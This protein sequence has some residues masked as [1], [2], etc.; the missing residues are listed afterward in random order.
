METTTQVSLG[1][2]A[3]QRVAVARALLRAYDPWDASEVEW[4]AIHPDQAGGVEAVVRRLTEERSREPV[5]FPGGE[6]GEHAAIIVIPA[7][8]RDTMTGDVQLAGG[9]VV[10]SSLKAGEAQP[11][12]DEDFPRSTTDAL[13]A[14]ALY[15]CGDALCAL[16]GT[17]VHDLPPVFVAGCSWPG[18]PDLEA[19]IAEWVR[20]AARSATG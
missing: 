5:H 4:A 20:D 3:E 14:V 13:P 1:L 6:P 10:T 2:P 12:R 9:A 15:P 17:L 8:Y 18:L 7:G 16:I 11:D 19:R